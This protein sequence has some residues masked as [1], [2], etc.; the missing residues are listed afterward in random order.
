MEIFVNVKSPG[1]CRPVLEKRGYV[2]PDELSN[3]AE[4]ITAIVES[5]VARFNT[6]DPSSS[7]VPFLTD[8]TIADKAA[9]GK[10][11]FGWRYSGNKADAAK[12][13]QN[14]LQSFEDGLY[15]LLIDETEVLRLDEPIHLQEGSVLTFI[16]LA[17]L[18]G[19][20]W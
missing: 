1:K 18:S 4:L 17:M 10:I 7:V 3:V 16:R 15:K 8:E 2:V 6:E 5:E 13:V 11:G 12:A 19:R 20:L 9:T 14:A